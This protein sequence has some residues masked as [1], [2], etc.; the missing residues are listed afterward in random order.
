MSPARCQTMVARS[1]W[2]SSDRAAGGLEVARLRAR[3]F[4]GWV[5]VAG[6]CRPQVGDMAAVGLTRLGRVADPVQTEQEVG[7][8]RSGI[9]LEGHDQVIHLPVDA[10]RVDRGRT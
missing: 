3:G 9:N 2:E 6:I 1:D 10:T 7:T 5:P 4:V 8:L